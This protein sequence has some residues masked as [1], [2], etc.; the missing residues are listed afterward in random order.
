MEDIRCD[1]MSERLSRIRVYDKNGWDFI[2]EEG[3]RKALCTMMNMNTP[4]GFSSTALCKIT[5]KMSDTILMSIDLDRPQSIH[6]AC[7]SICRENVQF[8]H[9]L[10]GIASIRPWGSTETCIEPLRY[11]SWHHRADWQQDQDGFS[12]PGLRQLSSNHIRRLLTTID[13]F[14]EGIATK[15]GQFIS[16]SNAKWWMM[17]EKSCLLPSSRR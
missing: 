6:H 17:W 7:N 13:P 3:T 14:S 4:R 16:P 12:F 15:G 10:S 5:L 8:F 2:I 9:P 11:G 1:K